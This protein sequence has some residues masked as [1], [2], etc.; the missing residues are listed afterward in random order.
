[1][2][3]LLFAGAMPTSLEVPIGQGPEMLHEP[4]LRYFCERDEF[5]QLIIW[6]A[7]EGLSR[8]TGFRERLAHARKLRE[9]GNNWHAAGDF[10][11][12]LHCV[13]GA[14]HALDFSP[15][16]Q[17]QL[18]EGQR[19]GCG[20]EMLPLMANASAIFLARGDHEN[21]VRAASA[22]L[23]CAKLLPQDS[24]ELRDLKA[25]LLYRRGLARAEDG[26]ARDLRWAREDLVAAAHLLPADREIRRCLTTCTS[27]LREDG[28][29]GQRPSDGVCGQLPPKCPETVHD[30]VAGSSGDEPPAEDAVG[31]TA[32]VHAEPL[33][34]P[35]DRFPELPPSLERFAEV[36]G[37]CLG[38]S[39]RVCRKVRACSARDLD[40]RA[41]AAAAAVAVAALAWGYTST[42]T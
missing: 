25:K 3:L 29:A 10:R 6:L 5:K 8:P 4:W 34:D 40:M 21:A 9:L 36:V 2:L 35:S 32:Q 13:M 41:A 17:M 33:L 7:E 16:E 42:A 31:N 30:P 38:R 28:G 24:A 27:L 14:V 37:R 20:R 18:S 26:P 15:S 19:S 12:A 22:G 23:R 1:M 39:R 11:R